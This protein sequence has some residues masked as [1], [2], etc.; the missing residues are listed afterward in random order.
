MSTT[1][2]DI[3]HAAGVSP[4][5]VSA[6]LGGRGKQARIGKATAERILTIAS[7]LGYE[8]NDLAHAVVSGRT[9]LIAIITRDPTHEYIGR[10]IHGALA[11]AA[12]RNYLLHLQSVSDDMDVDVAEAFARC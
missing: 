5:A 3:A 10:L 4:T 9:R 6:V 8:R 12:E 7:R 11:A 1:I 2:Y